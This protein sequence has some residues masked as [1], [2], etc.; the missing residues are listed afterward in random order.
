ML[1]CYFFELIS[2]CVIFFIELKNVFNVRNFQSLKA[3]NRGS[4]AQLQLPKNLFENL[5]PQLLILE[6]KG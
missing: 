1:L 4:E 2:T 3:V 5:E 6:L